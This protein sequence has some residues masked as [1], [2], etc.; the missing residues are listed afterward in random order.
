MDIVDPKP[1]T[2]LAISKFDKA[3]IKG[4]NKRTAIAMNNHHIDVRFAQIFKHI[5]KELNIKF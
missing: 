5:G 2:E 3:G 1:I 4:V